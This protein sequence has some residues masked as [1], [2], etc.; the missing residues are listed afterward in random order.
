MTPQVLG[1]HLP[2]TKRTCFL[3]LCLLGTYPIYLG[4]RA[5]NLRCR[6]QTIQLDALLQLKHERFMDIV[7]T[8]GKTLVELTPSCTPW[9]WMCII[10]IYSHT[11]IVRIW[12]FQKLSTKHHEHLNATHFENILYLLQGDFTDTYTYMYTFTV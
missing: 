11:G 12:T 1:V 6:W 2:Q 4:S 3:G 10:Y 8:R 7:V 9:I 5:W